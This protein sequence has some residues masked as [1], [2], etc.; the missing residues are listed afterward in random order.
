MRLSLYFRHS[1][2]LTGTFSQPIGNPLSAE[3]VV[4]NLGL[5]LPFDPKPWKADA[6]TATARL[7]TSGSKTARAVFIAGHNLGGVTVSLASGA[8]LSTTLAVPADTLDG[9]SVIAVKDLQG[10]SG[11][12]STTFDVVISG[13]SENV[14]IVAVL[15]LATLREWDIRWGLKKGKRYPDDR[16]VT[17]KEVASTLE[18]GVRSRTLVGQVVTEEQRLAMEQLFADARGRSRIW[19][20]LDVDGPEGWLLNFSADTFEAE[21]A[22]ENLT[23]MTI[24][25]LETGLGPAL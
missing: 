10:L 1:D 9:L 4:T 2:I 6:G 24:E 13:H 14:A 23:P 21:L 5:I 17:D 18:S 3:Y 25:A 16:V 7:T 12:T 15:W 19:G 8:G 22:D 11:L 20:A